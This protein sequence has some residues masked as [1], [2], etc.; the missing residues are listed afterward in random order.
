[1]L[2]EFEKLVLENQ[3]TLLEGHLYSVTETR[4]DLENAISKT[5]NLLNPPSLEE[6]KALNDERDDL[7]NDGGE[8]YD[9]KFQD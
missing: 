4:K 5:K 7:M 6:S 8:S 3:I 9:E 2:S 1:M